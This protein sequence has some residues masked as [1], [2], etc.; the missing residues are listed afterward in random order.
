MRRIFHF[1]SLQQKLGFYAFVMSFVAMVAISVLSYRIAR[2]QIREDREQ[3]MEVYT[4]QIAQD[5]ELE[6]RNATQE[7]QL[8]GE[9]EFVQASLK[10]SLG[11]R[12]GAFFDELI[13]H[14]TKYD[15][16]FTVGL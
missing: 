12:F 13:R 8:W 10:S 4:Q 5:L 7:L 9:M 3:L 11:E 2:D 15:L 14:Q 6:L 1:R 16:I